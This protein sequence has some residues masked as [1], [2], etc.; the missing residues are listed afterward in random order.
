[1]RDELAHVLGRGV[2][3]AW[4]PDTELLWSTWDRWAT[5]VEPRSLTG[6]ATRM[7]CTDPDDQKFIDLALGHGARW[8][9][10][11]D[12]AVLKVAKRS[13]SLGLEVLTPEAWL[14]SLSGD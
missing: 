14:E 12:S 6:A 8:L 4:R 9:I 13:R 2:G 11:R 1:M 5:M 10:S 3:R 7:R